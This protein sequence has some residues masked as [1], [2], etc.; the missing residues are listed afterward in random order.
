MIKALFWD[1]DG[2]L[3]ST[4]RLYYQVSAK[5]LQQAGVDLTLDQFRRGSLIHGENLLLLA[6]HNGYSDEDIE[7]LKR[8]RNS[9]YSKALHQGAVVLDGVEEVLKKLHGKYTMGVVTAAHRTDVEIIHENTHLLKY[10]D[11]V[12]AHE[13]FERSKPD[14]DPYLK[15]IQKVGYAPEECIAIEDSQRGVE[16]AAAAGIKCI[17]IPTE[18]TKDSDFNKAY[19]VLKSA[20]EVLDVISS[21]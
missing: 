16:S 9:L 5:V 2:T 18:M 7:E 15:A 20:K 1:N 3:V 21:I 14:A 10:F 12:L 6:K 13:D 17:A 4:E 11:F 19:A 8:K